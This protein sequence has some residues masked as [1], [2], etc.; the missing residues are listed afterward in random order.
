M[1]SIRN[2]I[3]RFLPDVNDYPDTVLRVQGLKNIRSIEFDAITQYI[4]WI[5]GRSFAIRKS[6]EN[7]THGLVVVPGGFGHPFDLALDPIGRLLFWSC[8]M[9]D[10]I[11]I[12]R[13]DHV[14]TVGVVVKGNSEKPRY[15]AIHPEMRL[16][17]WTDI[18][19]TG[20]KILL[21]KMDGR[22]RKIISSFSE[23]ASGL[24][25][26][27][28]ANKIYWACG[29]QIKVADFTGDNKRILITTEQ[30]SIVHLSVL[31]NYVYWYD[32]NSE[33]VERVEKTSG[34]NR[35]VIMQKFLT[36]LTAVKTPDNRVMESHMCSPSHDYGGCS[37]LC[38]GNSSL[39]CSCPQALV[40]NDDGKTCREAPT[41]GTEHFTCAA[42][43]S[44]I[45]QKCIP[46]AWKCDGQDDCPDGSDE[47]G[48]PACGHDQFRCQNGHCI[49][50][51]SKIKKF[52]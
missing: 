15:L 3:G 28:V 39:R 27:T 21:S 38:I 6:L 18:G 24:T 19:G 20:T 4:Y 16:L 29:K 33:T 36:D 44:A 2:V 43:N 34:F 13:L 22:D 45:A 23:E 46:A 11:N 42:P 41:C 47:L 12:T 10:A 7:K 1:Y 35:T 49:G 26:D 50:K 9:N 31:L 5:D 40:L 37:H 51:K 8:A 48:C 30:G 25:I 17:A 32:R 52:S 14:S